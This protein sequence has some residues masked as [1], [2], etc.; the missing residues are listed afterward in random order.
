M[1]NTPNPITQ[2][3][4][5]AAADALL[6]AKSKVTI[7][8]IREKL[9]RGSFTTVKKFL[10]HWQSSRSDT[11]QQSSPV[12]PQLESLWIEARRAA[13]AALGAEREA[14]DLLA[15]ELE[16]RFEEMEVA[17]TEA[18]NAR[19]LAEVRLAD[20]S[21][22]LDRTHTILEDLRQQRDRI[23]SKLEISEAA[24][25]QERASWTG[26]LREMNEQFAKLNESQLGLQSQGASFAE[27]MQM[28]ANA[29]ARE[30]MDFTIS[31]TKGRASTAEKLS[32]QMASLLDP[33]SGISSRLTEVDRQVRNLN[34]RYA[35]KA[36]RGGGR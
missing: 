22:E 17:M 28:S 18:Q 6:V 32:A 2:D 26:H 33:I 1:S 21:T 29:L 14:L 23:Q 36:L 20:K 25:S 10:D 9:G 27:A 34:R 31:E 12:P 35:H 3:E 16:T 30:V 4:V 8:A 24:L 15:L 19:R 7:L 11:Q 13:V 5:S